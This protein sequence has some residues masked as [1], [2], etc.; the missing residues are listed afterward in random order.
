MPV[1]NITDYSILTVLCSAKKVKEIRAEKREEKRAGFGD[2][3][4]F[5]EVGTFHAVKTPNLCRRVG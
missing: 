1:K 5:L 3:F 2:G 4:L